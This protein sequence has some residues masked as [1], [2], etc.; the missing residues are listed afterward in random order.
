MATQRQLE[1]DRRNARRST[2]PRTGE[3]RRASSLQALQH[4]LRS[5][6]TVIPGEDLAEY[7]DL[8]DRYVDLFQPQNIRDLDA[9]HKAVTCQWRLRRV[10]A[11][12]SEMFSQTIQARL[13]APLD[14]NQK[15]AAAFAPRRA[16]DSGPGP[17][18]AASLASCFLGGGARHF[19]TVAR[20]EASLERSQKNAFRYLDS[21]P[22]AVFEEEPDADGPQQPDQPSLAANDFTANGA[23]AW[24]SAREQYDQAAHLSAEPTSPVDSTAS[25]SGDPDRQAKPNQP[26][27]AGNTAPTPAPEPKMNERTQSPGSHSL[28]SAPGGALAA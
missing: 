17:D 20:Y 1:A 24:K 21:R 6:L 28:P 27:P 7:Q 10:A 2:G 9:V 16:P 3:G 15:L 18:S 23:E 12:E 5:R 26:N 25:R 11:I 4:S 14:P 13:R 8:F 19:N 22:A